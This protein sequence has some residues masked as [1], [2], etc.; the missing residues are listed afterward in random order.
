MPLVCLEAGE[1]E[2]AVTVPHELIVADVSPRVLDAVRR[3]LPQARCHRVD[4]SKEPLPFSADVII[5][6][7]VLSRI[8]DGAAAIRHVLAGLKSG[9]LLLMDDRSAGRLLP[10]DG[11]ES[12]APKTYRRAK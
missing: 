8:E 7:N 10:K 9:G 1:I 11:F 2:A 3:T 4:L 12:V 6:F 5:A